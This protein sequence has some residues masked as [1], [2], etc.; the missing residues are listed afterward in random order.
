MTKETGNKWSKVKKLPK[1][2]KKPE[3]DKKVIEKAKT[4]I[5]PKSIKTENIYQ[6]EITHDINGNRADDV[7]VDHDDSFD[8]DD[9]LEKEVEIVFGNKEQNYDGDIES[10][11]GNNEINNVS[12][13]KNGV[14]ENVTDEKS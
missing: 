11:S 9:E 10:E 1:T 8:K 7:D 13:D 2:S 6:V 12:N 3:T 4:D 14:N 5:D